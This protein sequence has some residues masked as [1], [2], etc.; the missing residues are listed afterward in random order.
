M[1]GTSWKSLNPSAQFYIP[2]LLREAAKK[3]S[4]TNGQAIKAL[5]PPL[6]PNGHRIFFVLK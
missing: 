3:S 1:R 2:I 5:P 4:S 6:V